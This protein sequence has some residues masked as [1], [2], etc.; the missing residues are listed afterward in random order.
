MD[1]VLLAGDA[2]DLIRIGVPAIAGVVKS[3]R[4][5]HGSIAAHRPAGTS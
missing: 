2:I 4:L 5:V 1:A 3:G